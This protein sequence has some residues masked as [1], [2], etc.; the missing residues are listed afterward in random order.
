M[1]ISI[2]HKHYKLLHFVI[3]LLLRISKSRN[4]RTSLANMIPML[5]C[6]QQWLG[7]LKQFLAL[8]SYRHMNAMKYI[9]IM[10]LGQVT[11]YIIMSLSFF[12][13]QESFKCRHMT[14][15][16]NILYRSIKLTRSHI[17]EP[18]G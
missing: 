7:Q 17:I 4:S 6:V 3:H 9:G 14:V 13:L 12:Y 1:G 16:S 18:F 8:F 5:T 10:Y 11:L 2:M 15:D